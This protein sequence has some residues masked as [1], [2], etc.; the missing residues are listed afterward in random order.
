M[1]LTKE[2]VRSNI[3][4]QLHQHSVEL[5]VNNLADA[6]MQ[7]QEKDAKIAELEKELATAKAALDVAP[8]EV[9]STQ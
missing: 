2:N 8:V 3:I 6:S 9:V 4:A 1:P 7:I 5:L